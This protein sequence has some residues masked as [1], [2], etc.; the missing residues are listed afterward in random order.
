M[1][2]PRYGRLEL[3]EIIEEPL[4]A[5]EAGQVLVR[6]EAT[7]LNPAPRFLAGQGTDFAGVVESVGSA[8]TLWHAGDEVLGHT[9]HGSHSD[10]VQ[11][12]QGDIIRKPDELSWEVAGSLY[13]PAVSAWD[14]VQ[15][16]RPRA[17]GTALVH[18]A[19]GA[20]GAIAAQLALLS[21]ATVIGT[22][23]PE[24]FDHLR[25]LGVIPVTAGPGL[26]GRVAQVAPQGIDAEIDPL[27]DAAM[28]SEPWTNWATVAT[29]AD[30]VATHQI[31]VPVVAVYPLDEVRDA[32]RER[33][34]GE[35]EGM[36]VLRTDAG[37]RAHG[38]P[39]HRAAG[40]DYS[41]AE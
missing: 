29:M 6:V 7:G 34:E 28:T 25:D 14:A 12:S 37:R 20:V 36:I 21:G 35:A 26:Q 4:P 13:I 5:P 2:F 10:H 17:G 18:A 39:R 41:P 11:V 27:V 33:Q 38:V 30:L 40:R 23:R 22:G 16:A 15:F 8:V 32:Y 9:L 1:K 31:V 19:G 3:L 24:S